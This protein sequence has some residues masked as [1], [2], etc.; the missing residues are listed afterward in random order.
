MHSDDKIYTD[1]TSN[2]FGVPHVEQV[3]WGGQYHMK[4]Q[5]QSMFEIEISVIRMSDFK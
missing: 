4:P 1:F 3:V 5:A 2:E